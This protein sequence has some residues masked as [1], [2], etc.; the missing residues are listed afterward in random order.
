MSMLLLA[1]IILDASESRDI[2][3]IGCEGVGENILYWGRGGEEGASVK[4]E[5][6]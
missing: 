5:K 4:A 2:E 1:T 3:D 6:E